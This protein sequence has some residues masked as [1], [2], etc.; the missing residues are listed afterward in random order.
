MEISTSIFMIPN[1]IILRTVL[2]ESR[3]KYIN[4]LEV[5]VIQF[6]RDLYENL[7]RNNLYANSRAKQV[8]E[9]FEVITVVAS[10]SR[11]SGL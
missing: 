11:S 3:T 8:Y 10:K 6:V 4:A 7:Y 2:I 9:G 5:Q 1:I